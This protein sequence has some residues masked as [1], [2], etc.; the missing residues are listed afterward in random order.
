MYFLSGPSIDTGVVFSPRGSPR[1]RLFFGTVY[2]VL[3]EWLEHL[4][5]GSF[6]YRDSDYFLGQCE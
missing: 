6:F 4:R 3:T 1:F 5:R 2:S